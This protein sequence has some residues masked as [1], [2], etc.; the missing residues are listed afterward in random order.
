MK[1]KYLNLRLLSI[2]VLLVTP[3]L[4]AQTGGD[5]TIVRST[6]DAGGGGLVAGNYQLNGTIGQAEAFSRSAISDNY[7]VT[8][9]FWANGALLIDEGIFQDGFEGEP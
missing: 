3:S 8:G 5:F 1:M 6:M 4:L 9:G 2:S 7:I